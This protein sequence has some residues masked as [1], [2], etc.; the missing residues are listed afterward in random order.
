MC[1]PEC[2]VLLVPV[3]MLVIGILLI[4]WFDGNPEAFDDL[5]PLVLIAGGLLLLPV[6][7]IGFA[8]Y[9]AILAAGRLL[10]ERK[11]G[12]ASR[13]RFADEINASLA[14][15]YPHLSDQNCAEIVEGLRDVFLIAAAKVTTLALPSLAVADA[16][17]AFSGDSCRR[18]CL[19]LFGPCAFVNPGF[20]A[21]GISSEALSTTWRLCCAHERIDEHFPD[22]LPRLFALD[23]RLAIPGGSRYSIEADN[24]PPG[25]TLSPKDLWMAIDRRFYPIDAGDARRRAVSVLARRV[26]ISLALER[27]PHDWSS[28]DLAQLFDTISAHNDLLIA[29]FGDI[30]TAN[31]ELARAKATPREPDPGCSCC[32]QSAD[33]AGGAGAY[34]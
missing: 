20:V 25:D 7:E 17:S 21:E 10:S 32:A 28:R 8:A 14:S 12:A 9:V 5:R 26:R 13:Y 16:W 3:G 34:R 2:M 33:A 4:L 30:A 19:H 1:I 24:H 11:E 27:Y 29:T 23:A 15:K 31:F 22:R 6:C 18:K